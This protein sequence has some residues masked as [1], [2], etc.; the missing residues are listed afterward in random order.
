M[1]V[2][3]QLE[4][5]VQDYLVGSKMDLEKML[6][7]SAI[8]KLD[9]KDYENG[10]IIIKGCSDIAAPDFAMVELVKQLQGHVKSIMYGEPCSTVP[11]FKRK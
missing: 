5:I 7:K 9:T 6:I 2:A 4:G 8:S 1:L 3:S 11:I 10:K